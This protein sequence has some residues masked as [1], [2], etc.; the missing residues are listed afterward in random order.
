MLA[1]TSL[2][3]ALIEQLQAAALQAAANGILLVDCL[4]NILWANPAVSAMTGYSPSELIG[5]NPR[6]FKSSQHPP[7]Y[8]HDLWQ[9]I[10]S[11]QVWR[12]ETIN[13]RKDSSLYT[14]EQTIT[15]VCDA[16]GSVTH[17][18][19]IKQDIT[20]RKQ[21]EANLQQERQR[22]FAILDGLPVLVYLKSP[23]FTIP[24]ANRMF[25]DLYGSPQG[26]TCY[27]VLRGRQTACD[28]CPTH[29]IFSNHQARHW[30]RRNE[31]GRIYQ[32]SNYPFVDADGSQLVLEIC[33]DITEQEQA[34]AR[35]NALNQELLALSQRLVEVQEAERNAIARELHDEAGQALTSLKVGLRLL[36]LSAADP[37]FVQQ[38]TASLQKQI[39]ALMDSLHRLAANLRPVSL[40]HLGLVPALRQ[41][42]DELGSYNKLHVNFEALNL[43]QRLPGPVETSV[44]RI[45]QEALTNI[46]RH[47]S[48]TQVSLLLERRVGRV[49]AVIED[50]GCG[51]NP[52]QAEDSR[53]L[54]LLGMRERARMAGGQVII[55]STPGG[56]TTVVVDIP[57]G[58]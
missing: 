10:L 15:P 52:E 1:S 32:V 33:Q 57:D 46:V 58:N 28:D 25:L 34:Q 29:E 24:Y 53:R 16:Q 36:E 11:G 9:T 56:G 41:K 40:D 43:E 6:I 2:N 49:I 21:T 3:G 30:Q 39:D 4:G 5:Q 13:R 12:G 35:L 17:F 18:I 38:T 44:Y 51:F 19:A 42:L 7:A 8:Y 14:E 23:A 20:S 47:A 55:E 54:G 31:N 27:E 50:N 48:A 37:Q 22:L 26:R 45:V